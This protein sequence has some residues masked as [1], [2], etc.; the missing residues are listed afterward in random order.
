[1]RTIGGSPIGVQ[2]WGPVTLSTVTHETNQGNAASRVR[3]SISSLR[4]PCKFPG[5]W[6]LLDSPLVVSS[7]R[8]RF[9]TKKRSPRNHTVG[10]GFRFR[11]RFWR[12]MA[13]EAESSAPRPTSTGKGC[14]SSSILQL[15]RQQGSFINSNQNRHLHL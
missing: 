5:Y 10:L 8:F 14:A 13:A 15:C 4:Q 9:P 2:P 12:A 6:K 1:P 3:A 7:V 11:T